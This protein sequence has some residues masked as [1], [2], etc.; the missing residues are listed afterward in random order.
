MSS[1]SI[2]I[3]EDHLPGSSKAQ[4]SRLT[5]Y[6]D[7]RIPGYQSVTSPP[8]TRI[9]GHQSVTSTPSTRIPGHQSVTSPPST[10]IPVCYLTNINQGTMIPV[11][12]LT[13][14]LPGYQNTVWYLIYQAT[15][16]SDLL[17]LPPWPLPVCPESWPPSWDKTGPCMKSRVRAGQIHHMLLNFTL[18][19]FGA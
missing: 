5:W 3:P 11:C 6:Q 9:P 13:T 18:V 7:T 19:G 4:S 8:S 17:L 1:K 16:E 2:P 10:R 15:T 12:Y 14:I